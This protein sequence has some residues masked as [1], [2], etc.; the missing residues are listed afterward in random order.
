M[1]AA[2][3]ALLTNPQPDC[4]LLN[5]ALTEQLSRINARIEELEEAKS[6]ITRWLSTLHESSK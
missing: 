1:N 2:E 5:N 3:V 6:T 4:P